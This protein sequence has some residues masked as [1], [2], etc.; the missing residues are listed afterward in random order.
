MPITRTQAEALAHRTTLEH[1]TAK[2]SDGSPKRC[3]VN[4]KCQTWKTRPDDFKLPVKEGLY[5]TGYITPL[6]AAEWSVQGQS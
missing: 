5:G 2:N 4:G 1:R 3:R 6:N